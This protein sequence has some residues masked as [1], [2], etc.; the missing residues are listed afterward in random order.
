MRILLIGPPGGGKGT[1][2]KFI[3][4]NL[5]IPQISTGDM[6]R[7]HVNNKTPLGIEA[8]SYMRNG[9]L[10][11]DSTILNMMKHRLNSDDCCN[12]YILDGFPRTIPQA[13]GL[14]GLLNNLK[15]TLDIVV[16]IDV[17]DDS[18]VKRMSGRRLH[19][20]SGRIYHVIY[21]PPKKEGFDDTT[22]EKLIIREDDQEETV[23]K[24]LEIYHELTSPLINYYDK[25]G[26]I[27]KVDGN[28]DIINVSKLI[29]KLIK[30]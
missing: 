14:D 5:K 3:V 16:V 18:I 15:Q 2:A 24:R 4:D 8:K 13:V 17:P 12:G 23:R 19:P 7:D 26:L 21:D 20:S 11:P 29:E 22:E 10:V 6:L 30:Q 1:Q 9:D 28:Q 27:K 25:K